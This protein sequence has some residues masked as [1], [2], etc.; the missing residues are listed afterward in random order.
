MSQ[1]SVSSDR[2]MLDV[3]EPMAADSLEA[4]TLGGQSIA[5]VELAALVSG[6]TPAGSY[7]LN[8][9]AAGQLGLADDDFNADE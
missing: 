9:A 6:G 4:S 3:L 5:L 8:L 2:P 1:T 7:P